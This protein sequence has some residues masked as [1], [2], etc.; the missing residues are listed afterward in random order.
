MRQSWSGRSWVVCYEAA[1]V[2]E[3]Q[4]AQ[5]YLYKHVVFG[6]S[7]S[8]GDRDFGN[9]AGEGADNMSTFIYLCPMYP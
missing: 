5:L 1:G 3:Q 2:M 7:L 6:Q 8:L 9:G 4:K